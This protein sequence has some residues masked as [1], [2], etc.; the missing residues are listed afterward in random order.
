M[1]PERD[2]DY[3]IGNLHALEILFNSDTPITLDKDACKR[4]S[5]LFIELQDILEVH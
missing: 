4:L 5:K 2:L 1:I 3:T